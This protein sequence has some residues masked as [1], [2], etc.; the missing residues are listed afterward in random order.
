MMRAAV[1][2]NSLLNTR[3]SELSAAVHSS[4]PPTRRSHQAVW[5]YQRWMITPINAFSLISRGRRLQMEK[6]GKTW[7]SW[8][9]ISSFFFLGWFCKVEVEEKK[10]W[11]RRADR[12]MAVMERPH[13][14]FSPSCHALLPSSQGLPSGAEQ[15]CVAE[16]WVLCHSSSL[17]VL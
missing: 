4:L 8:L 17:L 15:A 7:N 14:S 5:F 1:R 11:L 10:K 3:L 13:H 12:A 6:E 2:R 16:R 9:A